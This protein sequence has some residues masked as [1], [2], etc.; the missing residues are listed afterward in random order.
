MRCRFDNVEIAG[1]ASV[2]PSHTIDLYDLAAQYGAEEVKMIM[3]STGIHKIRVAPE[4]VTTADLCERAAGQLLSDIGV[5][6][7]EVD[8]IVFVSQTPDYI[9]P[10]TSVSLQHRLGLRTDIPA[11][12]LPYGC[13]GYIYGLFQAALLVGSRVCRQVL[14][15]AG[16]T[17]SRFVHPGDKPLRM[18]FGD[19]GSATLVRTGTHRATFA[20]HSDGSGAEQLI[21]PAGGCRQPRSRATALET[22]DPQG[23]VRTAE[24]IY[25]N[26]LELMT[27]ALREVPPVIRETLELAGW[28]KDGVG[29]YGIHQTSK[30]MVDY[31]AK[32][33]KLPQGSVPV[34]MSETGNTGPASIPLLLSVV[35]DEFPPQ[36]R[37]QSVLCG[38]GVGYS[39]G[40][41]AINLGSTRILPPIEFPCE[42]GV[43]IPR[44]EARSYKEAD[45]AFESVDDDVLLGVAV[46]LATKDMVFESWLGSA[47]PAF[48][49][50]HR[51]FD[52]V[53]FPASGFLAMAFAAGRQMF[54][55]SRLAV[56]DLVIGQALV[57]TE[58]DVRTQTALVRSAHGVGFQISSQI[59]EGGTIGGGNWGTHVSGK[60]SLQPSGSMLPKID[61]TSLQN[62]FSEESSV[63]ACYEDFR[64]LRGLDYGPGFRSIERL[65]RKGHEALG[66]ISVS[67]DT[68]TIQY[69]FHPVWLDGAIQ[70]LLAAFPDVARM[71]P[72]LPIGLEECLFYQENVVV[73]W[74]QASLRPVD[75]EDS[76]VLTGD[77]RL[78]TDEGVIV[79]QMRGFSLKRADKESVLRP[80]SAATSQSAF[81]SGDGDRPPVHPGF[82]EQLRSVGEDRV[83]LLRGYVRP[84]VASVLKVNPDDL[85][86]DTVLSKLGLDSL[87]AI[88][89]RNYVAT[90]LSIDVPM[91]KFL[92]KMSVESMVSLLEGE[93]SDGALVTTAAEAGP[94]KAEQSTVEATIVS[95]EL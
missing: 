82:A 33:M 14:L 41:C 21:V 62:E 77:V 69:P 44:T 89:L 16:D 86:D 20:L 92:R 31:L 64:R 56:R 57:L 95:G 49:K 4:T 76:D 22:R 85:A 50:D 91:V 38:F 52:E 80:V 70:I 81:P 51:V 35:R 87:R 93:L 48:L 83:S 12:D 58:H 65:F 43:V 79:C 42:Q 55:S 18:S 75:S 36:R 90:D 29:F 6:R 88:E 46:P 7:G 30:F 47:R 24:N 10:A 27:F 23:N 19:G 25:M 94:H 3:A 32:T 8:G 74:A 59:H 17:I 67:A 1:I 11:F 71:H 2:I 26:G 45:G 54:S 34:G 9:L 66:R 61:M 78:L 5:D 63:P 60:L 53:V 40:A 72:Y 28:E 37:E 68:T 73:G 15:C 13:S 84:L 39:W